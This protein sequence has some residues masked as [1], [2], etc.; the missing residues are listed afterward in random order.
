MSL[1]IFKTNDTSYAVGTDQES[2]FV[3]ARNRKSNY[4]LVKKLYL[5]STS[6]NTWHSNIRVYGTTTSSLNV[7]DGSEGYG[8]KLY[9]GSLEPSTRLWDQIS[10]G[11]TAMINNVG[12]SGTADNN[13]YPLWVCMYVPSNS[14]LGLYPFD[15]VITSVE[16][17]V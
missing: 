6:T 8:L 9:Y 16:H 13:M 2:S 3:I 10:Y 14:E 5:A 17:P 15:L 1:N 4:P 12:T 7:I 11:N